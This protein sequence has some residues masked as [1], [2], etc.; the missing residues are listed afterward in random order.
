MT[1]SRAKGDKAACDRMFSQL[2]RARGRCQFT[3]CN[4]ADVV[5]AHILGRRFVRVRTCE[6]NAWALCPTHH[7]LV[8][9]YPDEKM[10]L[11]R[12]TIGVERY[13]ELVRESQRGGQ[14]FDWS[15]ERARLKSILERAA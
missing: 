12:L 5:T 6:D 1:V 15:A 4:R 9:N 8:D 14:R 10:G 13:G 3:G 7:Y 2:V 11:V